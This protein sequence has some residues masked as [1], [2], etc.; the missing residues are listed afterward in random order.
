MD[1]QKIDKLFDEYE[2]AF[3][4]FNMEA[5]GAYYD[6]SFISAGP[7][8]LIAWNKDDFMSKSKQ[9]GDMYRTLGQNSAKIIS[10][11]LIPISNEYVMVTVLWAV[12]FE[13][14]GD[15]RIEF[16][17]SYMIQQIAGQTKIILFITHQDEAEAMNN[18]GLKPENNN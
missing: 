14:T 17:V 12:T 18:P 11:K 5:I 13:K 10:R 8:G 15:E 6:D 16:D 9:A 2:K 1:N 3:D 4:Q 7:K